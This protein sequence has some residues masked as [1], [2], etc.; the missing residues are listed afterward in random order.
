MPRKRKQPEPEVEAGAPEWMVTFSDC[1]TLLLTFFVLL[2]SFSSFDDKDDFVKMSSSFAQ[3]ISFGAM[4]R[5]E[6]DSVFFIR[7]NVPLEDVNAGSE[8]KTLVEGDKDGSKKLTEPLDFL[9]FK[10]FLI[11]SEEAFLG[12]SVAVSAAG[13]ET[14]A[15]LSAYLRKFPDHAIILSESGFCTSDPSGQLGIQRVW[16]VFRYLTMQKNLDPGQ[17]NFSMTSTAI[18]TDHLT[19]SDEGV[20]K[21]TKRVLEI[22]LLKQE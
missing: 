13:K 6:D 19:D 21:Q 2:L 3:Q 16:S 15:D 18:Q 9:R 5:T 10:T 20:S 11:P 17:F 12:D 1:M 14:L 22:V 4:D 7:Q 8:K